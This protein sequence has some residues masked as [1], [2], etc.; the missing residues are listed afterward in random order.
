MSI[1]NCK[2]CK[3]TISTKAKSCPNC[4]APVKK[5]S[6]LGCTFL[7]LILL[8]G[9]LIFVVNIG[10]ANKNYRQKSNP[11]SNYKKINQASPKQVAHCRWFLKNGYKC[12]NKGFTV[13]SK[14]FKKVYFVAV[15]VYGPKYPNGT[16]GVWS[17]SG[18]KNDPGMASSVNKAA[19]NDFSETDDIRNMKTVS[20]GE[21]FPEA[22]ALEKYARNNL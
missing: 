3:Q 14:S 8:I 5:K 21:R 20:S 17:H 16:I 2:E 10:G 9:V 7:I 22:E 1:I 19:V 6:L 12:G 13:K 11:I 15:K 18:E 4:G